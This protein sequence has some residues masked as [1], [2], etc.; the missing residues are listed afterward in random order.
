MPFCDPRVAAGSARCQNARMKW[1]VLILLLSSFLLSATARIPPEKGKLGGTFI[2]AIVADDGIVIGS[3]SRSTF[4]DPDDKPV[5]YVDRMPKIYVNHGPAV[6]VAGLTSVEDELLSS[7][8]R[9]NDYLLDSSTDQVLYEVA[10]KLPF[11]NTTNVLMLSGGLVDGALTICAKA[12]ADP[13]TC[14][15]SGYLANK[16]SPGLRRWFEAQQGHVATASAAATALDRAIREAADLDSTIG[17]PITLLEIPRRGNPRWLQ[18]PPNDNGW[19]RVCDI[20]DSYRSGRTNIFFIDTK[21]G[22]DGYLAGVCPSVA[23]QR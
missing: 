4:I 9:R 14:R 11:R 21:E 7:F 5:G 8:L 2:G 6:A 16:N 1:P 17:G 15:K 23:S 18:N 19:T 3:D 20:V 12:P 10:H 13:Q 22:L